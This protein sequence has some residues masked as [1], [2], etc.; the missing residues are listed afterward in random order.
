MKENIRAFKNNFIKTYFHNRIYLSNKFNKILLRKKPYKFIFI[1]SHMRSGSS[2]LTHILVSN[3]AVIGFGESHT[4]YNSQADFNKLM[5][6]VYYQ[7]QEFSQFPEHL[8]RLKMNETY[9]LDKILHNQKIVNEKLIDLASIAVIFLVREPERTLASLLDLKPHWKQNNAFD[10]YNDRLNK[11]VKYAEQINDPQRSL[12][13]THEQMLNQT[14]SALNKL[15]QFLGTEQPF[16]EEYE[17]TRS[18]GQKHVGDPK[19]N[20]KAGKIIREKR[21]LNHQIDE[22][23]LT[24]SRHNYQECCQKLTQLCSSITNN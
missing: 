14:E 16:S 12:F 23:L 10:Y 6:K 13:L 3:H 24:E 2:L 7:Y 1:L 22:N 18:T 9:V 17:L 11:L 20:I 4:K 19:G 21:K 8:S 5:M 15:Q